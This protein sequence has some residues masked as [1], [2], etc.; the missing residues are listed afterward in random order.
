M[1]L[2]HMIYKTAINDKNTL[3]IKKFITSNRID[4]ILNLIYLR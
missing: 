3:I 2:K 4:G 1:Y